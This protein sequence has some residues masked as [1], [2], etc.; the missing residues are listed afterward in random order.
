MDCWFLPCRSWSDPFSYRADLI[1]I[2][3][4]V[5]LKLE[6]LDLSG[7]LVRKWPGLPLIHVLGIGWHQLLKPIEFCV[8]LL[9]CDTCLLSSLV[10][11][12]G[13]LIIQ[14]LASMDVHVF[15][16]GRLTGFFV[17]NIRIWGG[18]SCTSRSVH[19]VRPRCLFHFIF[20][21]FVR[22]AR[23]ILASRE[24]TVPSPSP[25]MSGSGVSGPWKA[26]VRH[27]Q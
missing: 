15:S 1:R 24:R 16:S 3:Y 9:S 2:V 11:V 7:G 14:F 27:P 8:E 23:V 4:P 10:D 6:V 12:R 25:G 17:D 13:D 19:G 22:E 26:S 21:L 18:T 5:K 20:H